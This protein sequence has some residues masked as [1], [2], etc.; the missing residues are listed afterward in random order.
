MISITTTTTT[1]TTKVFFKSICPRSPLFKIINGYPIIR[2]L[3][4]HNVILLCS[5]CVIVILFAP[6]GPALYLLVNRARTSFGNKLQFVL[7]VINLNIYLL[8]TFD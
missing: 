4:Y 3:R 8:R 1:T 2:Y 5:V 6:R 7:K